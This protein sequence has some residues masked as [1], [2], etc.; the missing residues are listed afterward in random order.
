MAY[1]S[2]ASSTM[3]GR[4]LTRSTCVAGHLE[5]FAPLKIER[6]LDL[7]AVNGE[8][9]GTLT[10]PARYVISPEGIVGYADICAD[11]T[12][13]CH[14]TELFTRSL[15]DSRTPGALIFGAS[16]LWTPEIVS[17]RPGMPGVGFIVT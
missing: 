10:M 9:S 4:S 17:A 7:A 8:P 12:R 15:P 13:R 5:S 16:R 14:P 11:Y 6:A 1:R 3:A 2:P